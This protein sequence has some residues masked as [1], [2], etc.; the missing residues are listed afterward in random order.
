MH[1]LLEGSHYTKGSGVLH[2][3]TR[4][5]PIKTR[6]REWELTRELSVTLSINQLT[7]AYVEQ[8]STIC[9]PTPLSLKAKTEL[10]STRGVTVTEH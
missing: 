9:E 6:G 3:I 10:F 5:Y 8:K 2:A 1:M 4:R 7:V